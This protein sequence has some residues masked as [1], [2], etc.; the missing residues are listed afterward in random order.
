[1]KQASSRLAAASMRR[2]LA[3][4][5]LCASASLTGA[6]APTPTPTPPPSSACALGLDHSLCFDQC[7]MQDSAGGMHATMMNGATCAPGEGVAFDG[8]DD[9][10]DLAGGARRADELRALGA[11]GRAALVLAAVRLCRRRRRRQRVHRDHA[12]TA[13]VRFSVRDARPRA[14]GRARSSSRVDARGRHGD[15]EGMVLYQDGAVVASTDAREPALATREPLDGRSAWASNGYFEA[16]SVDADLGPRADAAEVASLHA[17]DGAASPRRARRRRLRRRR[18][19]SRIFRRTRVTFDSFDAAANVWRDVSGS[20]FDS[21]AVSACTTCACRR[22]MGTTSTS[23]RSTC[24]TRRAELT[25]SGGVLGSS[26]QNDRYPAS[27][28][29]DDVL[30]TFCHTSN[31]DGN[32]VRFAF[33]RRTR[34]SPS[35]HESHPAHAFV[36]SRIIGG[37]VQILGASLET[38]GEQTIASSDGTSARA[39]W[40]SG[41]SPT[42]IRAPSS[43]LA[44]GLGRARRAGA[45]LGRALGLDLPLGL[46]DHRRD[47]HDLQPDQVDERARQ[48]RAHHPRARR[49][50]LVP[51][52]VGIQCQRPGGRRRL[53]PGLADAADI[54]RERRERVA[55]VLRPERRRWLLPREWRD[56]R[57]VDDRRRRRAAL[58][59]HGQQAHRRLGVGGRGDHDVGLCALASRRSSGRA[60]LF[61]LFPTPTPRRRRPRRRRRRPPIT[62]SP[63]TTRCASISASSPTR[64]AA[65]TRR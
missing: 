14:R 13:A 34:R 37:N 57:A 1:M 48:P 58:R 7:V 28:C 64:S 61:G 65:W 8:V 38:L 16:R 35:G 18:R 27:N 9:Y 54:D 52:A 33:T 2:A 41:R 53:L 31:D 62:G 51:R 56:R 21:N 5:A 50:R 30:S 45:S 3:V 55:A 32:W 6:A 29:I 22:T 25:L 39:A 11:L 59:E 40:A 15:V 43:A 42:S 36:Y 17:L 49:H 60:H 10:A 19:P 23:R 63:S 46:E 12:D 4:V 26:Y 47:V 44:A 24:T 20:G